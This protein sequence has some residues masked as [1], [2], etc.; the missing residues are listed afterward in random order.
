MFSS[1][2]LL[3]ILS[4]LAPDDWTLFLRLRARGN[5]GLL[6]CPDAIA[7]ALRGIEQNP[8]RQLGIRAARVERRLELRKIA[9]LQVRVIDWQVDQA[10]SPLVRDA[11]RPTRGRWQ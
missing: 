8:A 1:R 4:P 6:I 7:F 5:Q 9:Q 11:F 2:A 10:L 3:V